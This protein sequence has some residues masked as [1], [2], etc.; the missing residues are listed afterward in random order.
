MA[1]PLARVIFG[2]IVLVRGL[3]AARARRPVSGAARARAQ[4]GCARPARA[5]LKTYRKS[6]RAQFDALEAATR[7]QVVPHHRR[8]DYGPASMNTH[9]ADFKLSITKALAD[10]LAERLR[11]LQP[12]PL[13][14]EAVDDLE[15]RSGVYLLYHSGDRVYVGKAQQPL[16]T[17]LKQHWHKLRGR[18][19]ISVS[20]VSFVALYVDEDLDAVAPEK[21]LIRRYRYEGGRDGVPWNVNGFGNKDPGRNRDR[22]AVE[23]NHFDAQY[24]ANLNWE[25]DLTPGAHSVGDLLADA[26][27]QLPYNL[28]FARIR[29]VPEAR[30][31]YQTLIDVTTSRL[32]MS[33]F[34]AMIVE[35][36]PE[37]WQATALPG[38]V[39]LY[40][41]LYEFP[42]ARI[43]W[44][45]RERGVY[46][47][48]KDMELAPPMDIAEESDD[49]TSSAS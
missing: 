17:R 20:D 15:R 26:K 12:H 5:G 32:H 4:E 11:P 6:S 7:T 40:N 22:S 39:I 35:A 8:T 1:L 49:D 18:E 2:R 43:L 23:S 21:L 29:D 13:T 41:Q 30:A 14:E 37:S 3:C 16:P 44:Q 34:M 28:R 38:Y 31:A 19:G 45:R 24:P 10:Q 33:D 25:L 46:V 47:L 42:S 9:V 48:R 36:L 27:Q